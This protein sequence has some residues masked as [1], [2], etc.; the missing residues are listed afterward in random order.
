MEDGLNKWNL[1]KGGVVLMHGDAERAKL[2]LVWDKI[3]LASKTSR[4]H[5]HS[6]AISEAPILQLV[7]WRLFSI[8]SETF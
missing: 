4:L 8:E 5:D 2:C 6:Q 3:V 1:W 7:S